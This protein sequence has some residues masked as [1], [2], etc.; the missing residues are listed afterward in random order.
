[1]RRNGFRMGLAIYAKLYSHFNNF[2]SL[3]WEVQSL[4]SV[5]LK[6]VLKI[7][8]KFTGKR[9]CQRPI[10]LKL[11]NSTWVFS[12]GF[13]GKFQNTF[14]AEQQQTATSELKK[15]GVNISH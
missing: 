11:Q 15:E 2:C 12:D 1:M 9:P 14:S 7:F 6:A 8:G 5:L 10:S 3:Y 4:R 13:S